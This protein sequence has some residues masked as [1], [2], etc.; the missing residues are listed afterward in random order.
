M[1]S[2]WHFGSSLCLA[3]LN[4]HRRAIHLENLVT[5]AVVSSTTAHSLGNVVIYISAHSRRASWCLIMPRKEIPT[6]T[7]KGCKGSKGQ[8]GKA[9]DGQCSKNQ[10]NDVKFGSYCQNCAPNYLCVRCD[11]WRKESSKKEIPP[12]C[13]CLYYH[14]MVNAADVRISISC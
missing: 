7:C 10:Q 12:L 5:F 11:C 4:L 1:L 9:H 6:C 8:R 14:R 2:L 3:G 13:L